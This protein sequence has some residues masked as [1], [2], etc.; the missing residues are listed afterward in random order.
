MDETIRVQLNFPLNEVKKPIIWH[1]G[2]DFGLKFSIRRAEI[3]IHIGG[4]TVL[5]LTGPRERIMAGLEWARNEGIETSFIGTDG[6][7]EWV[8]R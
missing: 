2:H 3:D 7:D 1:L 5:D 8:L 4:F 6:A